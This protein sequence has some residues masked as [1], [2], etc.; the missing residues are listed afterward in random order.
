MKGQLFSNVVLLRLILRFVQDR[1]LSLSSK[2]SLG[3]PFTYRVVINGSHVFIVLGVNV[4]TEKWSW[5]A[6]EEHSL[7]S[8]LIKR[9]IS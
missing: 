6:Q 7:V 9:E 4:A 5:K 3:L 8:F 1:H 2:I